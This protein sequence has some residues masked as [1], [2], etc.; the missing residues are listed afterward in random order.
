[1]KKM[2]YCRSKKGQGALANN[3]EWAKTKDQ[4]A[5]LMQKISVHILTLQNQEYN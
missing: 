1:M 5:K 3:P 4:V 2:K